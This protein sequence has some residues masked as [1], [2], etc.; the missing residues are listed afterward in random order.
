[1]LY[2]KQDFSNVVLMSLL[3]RTANS[4]IGTINWSYLFNFTNDM[5]KESFTTLAIV[6]NDIVT[7]SGSND[8]IIKL[9]DMQTGTPDN[10]DGEIKLYPKGYWSYEVYEQESLTNL[11]VGALVPFKNIP[12]TKIEVGKAYVYDNTDEV[13]YTEHIDTTDTTNY[14]YIK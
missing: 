8:I 7:F 14:M 3:D 4:H 2:L 6:G 1:V 9:K 5:T 13:Q 10:L 12:N 11:A